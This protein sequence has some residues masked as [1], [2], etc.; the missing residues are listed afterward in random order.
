MFVF[1]YRFWSLNSLKSLLPTL[2][3]LKKT[4]GAVTI[5]NPTPQTFM[6]TSGLVFSSKS[7]AAVTTQ[8]PTK[9]T[10]TTEHKTRGGVNTEHPATVTPLLLSTQHQRWWYHLAQD[11]RNTQ[12]KKHCW[13]C[14]ANLKD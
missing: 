3:L 1:V 6:N 11:Q 5:E 10:F 7:V 2:E 9:E 4:K 14:S 13:F 8:E 12:D